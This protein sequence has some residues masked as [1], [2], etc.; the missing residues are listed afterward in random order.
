[1]TTY[2]FTIQLV[3]NNLDMHQINALYDAGCDDSL[4]YERSHKAYV[5]FDREADTEELAEESARSDIEA[6]G[7]HVETFF[8]EVDQQELSLPA[9][10]NEPQM[11]QLNDTDQNNNNDS[12]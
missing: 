12:N 11:G 6:A 8:H 9:E 7:L 2:N 4:V 1:M 10:P 3:E 5:E